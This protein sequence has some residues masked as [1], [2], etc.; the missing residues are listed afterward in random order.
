MH[1]EEH[2]AAAADG[3]RLW[4][5][6]AGRGSAA[7]AIVLTDG[8]GCAGYIWRRL[9]PVLA[10]QRR[11]VHWNYRGHGHSE[12]PRDPERVSIIDC[13]DD[14]FTVLDA[15]G[16]GSAVLAGHSMGVQVC[17]EA[18][19]RHRER[20]RALVLV[21]G[22]PGRTLDTF[23]GGPLL[24]L[25]FPYMKELVLAWPAAARWFLHT[26]APTE[27]AFQIGLFSEVNR[28]LVK[29]EDLE[30]YLKELSGVDPEVFV[31]ILAAASQHD[32]SDH[33]AAVDVP[34]LVIAGEK[35]TFTAVSLSTSMH[36]SIPGSELLLLPAGSHIA[37]LEHPE[38]TA[39]RLQKFLAER[40]DRAERPR[41]PRRRAHRERREG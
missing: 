11:V 10:E 2:F 25:A 39:L 13:V 30:A 33:L 12:R 34:T 15:A 14:L 22:A 29:R 40:V 32:A 26:L 8:I 5:R 9:L 20:V 3:T 17:L 23:H 37:P 16:E 24:S 27:L 41:A 21:C 31:R 38:L 1:V 4:W 36:A 18:H 19:R 35:D 7:P 6:A 28:Q